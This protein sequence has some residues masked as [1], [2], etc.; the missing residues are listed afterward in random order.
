M[1]LKSNHATLKSFRAVVG[2]LGCDL[3]VDAADNVI[4]LGFD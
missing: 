3:P 4:A 1:H 2:Q